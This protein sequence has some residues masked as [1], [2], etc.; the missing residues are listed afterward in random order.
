M[1]LT[2]RYFHALD[3]DGSVLVIRVHED[4]DTGF[5]ATNRKLG[6]GKDRATAAEAVYQLLDDNAIYDS[7]ITE[8]YKHDAHVQAY[9]EWVYTIY[10]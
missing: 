8:V 4:L 5:Y 2:A 9:A 7:T 3:R 6:C 10:H 1:A